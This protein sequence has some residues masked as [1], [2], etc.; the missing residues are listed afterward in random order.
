MRHARDYR[1]LILQCNRVVSRRDRIGVCKTFLMRLPFDCEP[2]THVRSRNPP[3]TAQRTCPPA[4]HLLLVV[5]C[6]AHSLHSPCGTVVDRL[7]FL[8][9]GPANSIAEWIWNSSPAWVSRLPDAHRYRLSLPDLW[10]D[11]RVRIRR[12]R[13]VSQRVSCPARGVCFGI[14]TLCRRFVLHTRCRDRKLRIRKIPRAS[15]ATRIDG[16]IHHSLWLDL[17]DHDVFTIAVLTP[18]AFRTPAKT[19]AVLHLWRRTWP[20]FSRIARSSEFVPIESS[21]GKGNLPRLFLLHS[22]DYP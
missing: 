20:N 6:F 12:S 2:F 5:S 1:G 3:R 16:C 19:T 7:L 15:R 21:R 22:N 11:Y 14:G 8:C 4:P 10:H 17:Q 9:C 13:S 18:Y